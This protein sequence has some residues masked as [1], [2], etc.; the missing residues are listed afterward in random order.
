M[1]LSLSLYDKDRQLW[2]FQWKTENPV[3]VKWQFEEAEIE[4]MISL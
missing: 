3:Y 4:G 2:R 1:L